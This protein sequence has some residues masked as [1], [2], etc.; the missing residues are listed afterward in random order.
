M[1]LIIGIIIILL[2]CLLYSRTEGFDPLLTVDSPN[3]IDV[4]YYE[5]APRNVRFNRG[6]G[7]MYVTNQQMPLNCKQIECPDYVDE[8]IT[9]GKNNYCWQC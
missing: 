8:S 3:L 6:G 4:N 9:L 5:N 2:I 1:Y 7:I